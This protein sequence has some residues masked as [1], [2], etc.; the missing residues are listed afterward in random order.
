MATT[1]PARRAED[2]AR[3]PGV[4]DDVVAAVRKLTEAVETLER[5]RGRLY[6]FHH[7]VGRVDFLF[8]DAA[9]ALEAAGRRDEAARL[10][11]DVVGRNVLSGRW[12]YQVLEEFD[13]VYYRPVTAI[14]GDVRDALVGGRRHVFEAELQRKRRTHGRP[15]HESDPRA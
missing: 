10:R 14:D 11:A 8:E 5:A 15:G 12:T 1:D 13:D 7:L 3:P 4:G 6:D 9:D 2:N